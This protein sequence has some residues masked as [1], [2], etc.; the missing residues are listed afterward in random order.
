MIHKQMTVKKIIANPSYLNRL[1]VDVYTKELEKSNMPHLIKLVEYIMDELKNPFKDPR[2]Y[3]NAN[4]LDISNE[5]L[6]YLLIEETPRT[7]KKGM[8]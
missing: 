8:I 3:R 6:F 2:K 5:R 4:N 7:F 1:D